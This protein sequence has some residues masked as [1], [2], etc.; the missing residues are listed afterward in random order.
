[1]INIHIVVV[2]GQ[3]LSVD[4]LQYYIPNIQDYWYG[5]NFIVASLITLCQIILGN[6]FQKNQVKD[7]FITTKTIV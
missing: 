2:S 3:K 7:N 4:M 1:M 6:Y 5:L